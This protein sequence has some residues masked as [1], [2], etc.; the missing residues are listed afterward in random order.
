M[1]ANQP[2]F[3][4][5]KG[6]SPLSVSRNE[7]LIV[8]ALFSS[9]TIFITL[10]LSFL[11]HWCDVSTMSPVP[12]FQSIVS[13]CYLEQVLPNIRTIAICKLICFAF[14]NGSK[15]IVGTAT[16]YIVGVADRIAVF[17]AKHGRGK[18]FF[19]LNINY[20]C[21]RDTQFALLFSSRPFL[22]VKDCDV[23]TSVH[24]MVRYGYSASNSEAMIL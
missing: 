4:K 17:W 3:H 5:Q 23:H 11:P 9:S 15:V 19:E 10:I 2:L 12:V 7:F 24:D 14:K 20:K 6:Q 13:Q 8:F 22:C 18:P 1:F 16:D 21:V